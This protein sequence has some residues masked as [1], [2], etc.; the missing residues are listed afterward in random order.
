MK[1]E[2]R[3]NILVQTVEKNFSKVNKTRFSSF[4]PLN[5]KE[6]A[7]HCGFCHD[8]NI[9]MATDCMKFDNPSSSFGI[10]QILNDVLMFDMVS[11]DFDVR[12]MS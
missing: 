3:F 8:I 2:S 12:F 7:L 9:L 1:F 10:Q 6:M 5:I 4:K 11:F